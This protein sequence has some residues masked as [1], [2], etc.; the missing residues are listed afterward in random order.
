MKFPPFASAAAQAEN[1][2]I[3]GLQLP[4]HLV[5]LLCLAS[6]F[7][8]RWRAPLRKSRSKRAKDGLLPVSAKSWHREARRSVRAYAQL[9]RHANG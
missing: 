5:H 7:R 6:Y 3:T 4:I 2:R 8:N 1:Y 9:L